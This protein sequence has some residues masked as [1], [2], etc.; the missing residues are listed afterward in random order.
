MTLLMKKLDHLNDRNQEVQTAE[1]RHSHAAGT[2]QEQRSAAGALAA[3]RMVSRASQDLHRCPEK[4][5]ALP[6]RRPRPLT[7]SK[8]LTR[9]SLSSPAHLQ[10]QRARV[11]ARMTSGSAEIEAKEA[12]DWLRAAGFPQYAQLYEDSQFPIDISSVKRDHD[13]LDRDLVEPLCR[14]LN[15]LNKCASMKL[16][17]SHPKKKDTSNAALGEEQKKEHCHSLRCWSIRETQKDFLQTQH[18]STFQ[19]QQDSQT[20]AGPP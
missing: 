5:E 8:P 3:S 13:F 4:A 19:T 2:D 6:R 15:T 17:V 16:D 20:E 12:C 9:S 7:R 11:A 10:A 14:R 18:P 1:S